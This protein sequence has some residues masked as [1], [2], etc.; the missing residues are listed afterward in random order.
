MAVVHAAL[1]V[2]LFKV[3]ESMG[4]LFLGVFFRH[5]DD[6]LHIFNREAVVAGDDGRLRGMHENDLS[7]ECFGQP[8]SF[9]QHGGGGRREVDGDKERFH[10]ALS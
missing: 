1:Y 4:E 10:D 9:L 5:G 8:G 6:F 3:P 2:L 7:G